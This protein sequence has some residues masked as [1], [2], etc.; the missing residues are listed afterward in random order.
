LNLRDFKNKINKVIA[1]VVIA[2]VLLL[3]PLLPDPALASY[4]ENDTFNVTI[5]VNNS[6]LS[7]DVLRQAAFF[8]EYDTEALEY[9]DSNG[10]GGWID[11]T[12]SYQPRVGDG[13]GLGSSGP[14]TSSGVRLSN[15]NTNT[16]TTAIN[17]SE[18]EFINVTLKVREGASSGTYQIACYASSGGIGASYGWVTATPASITVEGSGGGN[19]DPATPGA[20]TVTA[21]ADAEAEDVTA[22]GSAFDVAVWLNADPTTS[23]YAAV[24]AEL[25]FDPELVEPILV[26]E[27]PNVSLS[28][29][30]E[31]ML[32]ISAGPGDSA[33]VG[34]GVL[35][36]TIPF[37][38]LAEGDAVF[39]VS[40]NAA[41]SLSGDPCTVPAESGEPL[42]VSIGAG[43]L[44]ITFVSTYKGLPDTYQLLRYEVP[45]KP[46]FFSTYAG[47]KMYYYYD[48]NES[49]HYLTCIV[50][51]GVS[52]ENAVAPVITWEPYAN[53]GDLNNDGRQR[54]SDAQIIYDLVKGHT[55]YT[56][57]LGELSIEARLKADLNGD[58]QIDQ[59]DIA[60]AVAAV[61]GAAAQ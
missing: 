37:A 43:A 57:Q 38:P 3:L 20:Y 35:L 15:E 60:A 42:S 22:G 23:E 32:I 14:Q 29:D 50:D 6:Q 25:V 24:D 49:K 8:L 30:A 17:E 33:V 26:P 52:L 51:S 47:E 61:H 36:A 44:P 45:E 18:T 4:T 31:N 12:I 16:P 7:K 2:S 13:A 41:I 48:G 9:L 27:V 58:G 10:V 53:D 11:G 40:D 39:T 1:A 19:S 34:D 21:V 5:S 54:I 56:S 46:T 59:A 28:N 55:N